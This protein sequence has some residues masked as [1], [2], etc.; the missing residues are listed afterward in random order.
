MV[1]LECIENDN[2]IQKSQLSKVVY[3]RMEKWKCKICM[4]DCAINE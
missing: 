3:E 4:Y 2:A 1:A